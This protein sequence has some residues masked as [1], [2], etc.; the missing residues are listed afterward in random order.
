MTET[1]K[2]LNTKHDIIFDNKWNLLGFTNVVFDLNLNKFR[3]Y[4]YDDYISITTGYNWK[5]PTD[6]EL[7][8]MN[9]LID[10]IMPIQEEKELYLQILSTTLDGKCLEKFI[11][12]NG[13]GGNGKG[14][15]NDLLLCALGNHAMIGNNSILFESSKT[16]SN[17]EKA[18]MHKKRLVLFR[19]PPEIKKFENSIIKE[20]TG[21]GTF[22]ARGHHESSTK[23]ELN[24]TMIVEANKKPLFSEEPTNA[25]IRRIIDIVFRSTYTENKNIVDEKNNIYLANSYYKTPEFQNKYKYALLKILM[26]AY[27]KHKNNNYITNVPKSIEERTKQYLELSCNILQWFK[28]NYEYTGKNTDICKMKDLYDNFSH[29]S[30]FTTFTKNEKRKYN[31][32]FF[33]EYVINNPFFLKYYEER[34]KVGSVRNSIVGW[35]PLD[36]DND[37]EN[38][39]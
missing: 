33:N 4:E 2:E 31:K 20:L 24:L 21:G 6:D 22:S 30:Y 11:I 1:Y 23:K 34:S 16:G 5:E 13:S 12:F 19:E 28:D 35:K 7:M 36:D 8:T 14:M 38:Y 27:V 37:N 39:Y 18:N 10:Q 25:D 26:N 17:P 32:S 15:I 3:E 29:S 9:N